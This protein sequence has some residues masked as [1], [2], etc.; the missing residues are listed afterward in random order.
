MHVVL[1]FNNDDDPR[2]LHRY[3]RDARRRPFPGNSSAR[4]RRTSRLARRP[5][6]LAEWQDHGPGGIQGPLAFVATP[7]RQSR[8]GPDEV[9]V[10]LGAVLEAV[11]DAQE[12]GRRAV[13]LLGGLHAVDGKEQVREYLV[14]A[15]LRR[16]F[17]EGP[18]EPRDEGGVA[19]AVGVLRAR[20]NG[21]RG[22]PHLVGRDRLLRRLGGRLF[23]QAYVLHGERDEDGAEHGDENEKEAIVDGIG[24]GDAGGRDELADDLLPAREGRYDAFERPA[25]L[26]ADE[27][28]RVFERA[29]EPVRRPGRSVRGQV[30]GVA[31]GHDRADDG[32]ADRG[33][34]GA[35]ELGRGG[36]DAEHALLDAVLHG[37]DGGRHDQTKPQPRDR[38]VERDGRLRGLNVQ[39]GQEVDAEGHENGA[40]DGERL[41]APDAGDDLAAQDPDEGH[42]ED[43]RREHRPGAGRRLAQRTLHEERRIQDD[44]EHPD[45]DE[46]HQHTGGDEYP[47]LEERE[48]DDGLP[49]P[50]LD[51]DED[52]EQNRGDDEPGDDAVRVPGV[53]LADPGEP[54]QQ[55]RDGGRD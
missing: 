54:E 9:R 43:E 8:R 10:V 48:R 34:E 27:G 36:G 15:A 47:A 17:A 23:R 55:R 32:G 16:V 11:G 5:Q 45:A 37:E 28:L 25:R 49:R 3:H 33:P 51:G 24:E 22:C 52:G 21:H 29:D 39:R 20:G 44:A 41:D 50:Q 7:I 1:A 12:G 30:F 6:L 2:V 53:A 38:E 4:L 26:V 31:L 46:E 35:D 40:H 18:C 13:P 14:A 19:R 42:G